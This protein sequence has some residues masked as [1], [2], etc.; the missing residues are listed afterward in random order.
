MR[1]AERQKAKELEN[2]KR[3]LFGAIES[4]A[5]GEINPSQVQ[6]SAVNLVVDQLEIRAQE[7]RDPRYQ[8][9]LTQFYKSYKAL[10]TQNP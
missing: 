9:L 1:S 8:K 10:R 3:V 5:M 2:F 4:C 6:N 7:T